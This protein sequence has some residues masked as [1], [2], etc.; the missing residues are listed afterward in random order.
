MPGGKLRVKW[1]KQVRPFFLTHVGEKVMVREDFLEEVVFELDF[2]R[3]IDFDWNKLRQ[4][5]L[6]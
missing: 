4:K 5:H 2:E 3:F 6:A 1:S